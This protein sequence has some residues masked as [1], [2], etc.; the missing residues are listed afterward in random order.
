MDYGVI[1]YGTLRLLMMSF[2]GNPYMS[3]L[4][5][6]ALAAALAGL[7][8]G[9]GTLL[10]EGHGSLQGTRTLECACDGATQQTQMGLLSEMA[11]V[12][13]CT[14]GDPVHDSVKQLEAWYERNAKLTSYADIWP[15]RVVCAY[16][17]SYSLLYRGSLATVD[18]RFV[19][20]SASRARSAATRAS[21]SSLSATPRTP[22]LRWRTRRPC[23]PSSRARSCSLKMGLVYVSV[24]VHPWTLADSP[25]QHTSL[26]GTSPCTMHAIG[27]YF[28]NGTLPAAGTVCP[29]EETMFGT[30]KALSSTQGR[31]FTHAVRQLARNAQIKPLGLLI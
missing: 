22:S 7:E 3:A 1:D 31:E 25:V 9:N 19:L 10:W 5:A 13:A 26:A 30:S 8:R 16:V 14:D 12:I 27:A 2:V 28:Q 18:G 11:V 4:T 24:L 29:V 17:S 23:L 6:P 21:P 15:F 20:W